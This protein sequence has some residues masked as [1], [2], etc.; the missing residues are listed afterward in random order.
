M[1]LWLI[2]GNGV[3]KNARNCLYG[4]VFCTGNLNLDGINGYVL[5]GMGADSWKFAIFV[6]YFQYFAE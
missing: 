2:V 6:L 3:N 4:D 5:C 1:H